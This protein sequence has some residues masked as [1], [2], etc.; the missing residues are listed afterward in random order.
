M[1]HTTFKNQVIT[2]FE[3]LQFKIKK[4]EGEYTSEPEGRNFDLNQNVRQYYIYLLK[5]ANKNIAKIKSK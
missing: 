3:Q 2:Q 4:C 5:N 1:A